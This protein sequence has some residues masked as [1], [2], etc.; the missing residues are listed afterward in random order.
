MSRPK[1][2]GLE[3]TWRT[4]SRVEGESRSAAKRCGSMKADPAWIGPEATTEG[5][6]VSSD[7]PKQPRTYR[8]RCTRTDART[9]IP[10]HD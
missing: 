10:R 3:H 1:D 8:I 2:L 4:R 5:A 9:T 7:R 6:S